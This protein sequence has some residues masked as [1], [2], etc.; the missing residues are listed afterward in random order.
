MEP[1]GTDAPSRRPC[2]RVPA[3]RTLCACALAAL[4]AGAPAASEAQVD[5]WLADADPYVGVDFGYLFVDY[6]HA[7]DGST[8]PE[9]LRSAELLLGSKLTPTSS[10]ELGL[11]G[12][13]T[14][15]RDSTVNGAA[16]TAKIRAKGVNLDLLGHF[17]VSDR[18]W[19]TGSFGVSRIFVDA[20]ATAPAIA[21]RAQAIKDDTAIRLGAG[22]EHFVRGRPGVAGEDALA[23]RAMYRYTAADFGDVVKGVQGIHLGLRYFF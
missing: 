2:R 1:L 17:P 10:V 8:Q 12:T 5:T 3:W 15:E 7:E 4:L 23:L 21:A 20:N 9:S 11:F 18:G 14:E 22:Y 16:V 6:E 19:V 13:L